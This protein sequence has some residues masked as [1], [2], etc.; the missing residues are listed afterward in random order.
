MINDLQDEL[1]DTMA[2]AYDYEPFEE[3][4]KQLEVKPLVQ[5]VNH[6]IR[7]I[8]TCGVET[9]EDDEVGEIEKYIR[10]P[11]DFK[12]VLKLASNFGQPQ[13]TQIRDS[14]RLP[15]YS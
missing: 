2:E 8:F 5:I 13:L 10:I 11:W 7:Q 4:A 3:Y 14:L 6:W 15:R 1:C 9:I 12:F